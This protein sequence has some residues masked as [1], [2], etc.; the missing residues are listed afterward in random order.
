MS[1]K[2]VREALFDMQ[3]KHEEIKK[4][5]TAVF[6]FFFEECSGRCKKNLR[7]AFHLFLLLNQQHDYI[8]HGLPQSVQE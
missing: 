1:S 2:L 7:M 4:K 6:F 8:I 5:D 3:M